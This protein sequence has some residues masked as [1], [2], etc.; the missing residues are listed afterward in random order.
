MDVQNKDSL[1]ITSDIHSRQVHLNQMDTNHLEVPK[2]GEDNLNRVTQSS[3]PYNFSKSSSEENN[4]QPYQ[5]CEKPGVPI[6]SVDNTDDAGVDCTREPDWQVVREN[7]LHD[8]PKPEQVHND[9]YWDERSLIVK[10]VIKI[11][12]Q[13][14]FTMNNTFQI[15][16]EMKL[17][18]MVALLKTKCWIHII[19]APLIHLIITPDFA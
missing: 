18:N 14:Y 9:R 10:L 15:G 13:S 2:V 12:R 3:E 1:G 5:H 8:H 6:P 4:H 16:L 17:M 11:I 19:K 7:D